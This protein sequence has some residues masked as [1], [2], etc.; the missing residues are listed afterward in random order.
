MKTFTSIDPKQLSQ[1]EMHQYLL[2]A[3]APRPIC[4]ASTIDALGMVNLSPFSFFNVFSSNPPMLI[5]SPARRGRDNT[6]KHTLENVMET[7]EVVVN[8]VNYPM[9]NQVALSSANFPKGEDEFKKAGFRPLKSQMVQPPRV[10]EAPVSFECVVDRVLPLGDGP[11]AGNLVLAKV[12]MMH[13]ET[14]FLTEEN[15]LAGEQMDLVARMGDQWY[16]RVTNKSLFKLPKSLG[17]IGIGVDALPIEAQ[18]S[19]VLTGNDLGILGNIAQFP[20][21]KEQQAIATLAAVQSLLAAPEAS[22]KEAFHRLAQKFLRSGD[23]TTALCIL[24]LSEKHHLSI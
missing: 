2:S 19:S 1:Q 11:G 3:V 22:Q 9:V 12:V 18:R 24:L 5:F 4:L 10:A 13:V 6:I 7:Q 8:V 17:E 15:T 23:P 16:T 21:K 14:A 20:S